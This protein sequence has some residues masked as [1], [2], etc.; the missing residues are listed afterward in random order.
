MSL[1]V[2]ELSRPGA[3]GNYYFSGSTGFDN[4]RRSPEA[5]TD[6]NRTV[7]LSSDW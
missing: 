5:S 2:G 3:R 7:L 1:W 4:L 6:G